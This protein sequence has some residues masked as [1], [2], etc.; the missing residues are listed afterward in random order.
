MGRVI[1]FFDPG[2]ETGWAVGWD[3]ELLA[4]GLLR[5]YPDKAL[6]MPGE[7]GEAKA[8]I[9]FPEYREHNNKVAINDLLALASKAGRIEERCLLWGYTTHRVKPSGWKGAVPKEIHHQRVLAELR[10]AEHQILTPV[11]SA[12][13][14]GI[15]HN[16]LD[17]VG[18]FLWAA[19]RE[20]LR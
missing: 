2:R 1:W 10:P 20:G 14:H 12:L 6:W 11:L 18:G 15:R 16:V 17:A 3:G 5:A 4:C 13:A 9:E 8:W 19:K 7:E